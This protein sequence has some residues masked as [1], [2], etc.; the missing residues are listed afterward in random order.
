MISQLFLLQINSTVD[1]SWL[2]VLVLNEYK[3]KLSLFL[4]LFLAVV[5]AAAELITNTSNPINHFM[6]NI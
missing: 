2:I 3:K 6:P 1:K 4:L 5:P